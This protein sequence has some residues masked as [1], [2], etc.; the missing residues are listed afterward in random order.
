MGLQG[1][2]VNIPFYI[3]N[4]CINISPLLWFAVSLK[5]CMVAYLNH[6]DLLDLYVVLSDLKVDFSLI[7]I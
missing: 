4:T 1:G 3:L 5:N 6:V 2:G 7:K